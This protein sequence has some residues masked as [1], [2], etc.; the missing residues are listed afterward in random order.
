MSKK[1]SLSIAHRAQIVVLSK[2]KLSER[3]IVK[4]FKVSK[5]AV[6]NAIEKF[7]NKKKNFCR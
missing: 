4:K 3:Q 7:K 6:H 1:A 5:T 2:M